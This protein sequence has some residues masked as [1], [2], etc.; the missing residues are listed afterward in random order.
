MCLCNFSQQFEMTQQ[1]NR[2]KKKPIAQ[3]KH[4]Q[5]RRV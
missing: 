2:K 3:Q 1:K 5:N 4:T